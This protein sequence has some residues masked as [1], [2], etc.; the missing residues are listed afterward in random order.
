M[1][2]IGIIGG[3]AAGMMAAAAALEAEDAEIHLFEKNTHLGAKVIISGGGRCN[4]TTGLRD[5]GEVLKRYP[6]GARFIRTAMYAFPPDAVYAWFEQHGVPLKTEKDLRV[7]PRSDDGHDVVDAFEKLFAQSKRVHVHLKT[8]AHEVTHKAG[9][10]HLTT[11]DGQEFVLDSLVLTT[12][13]Q[14]YRQTG[15]TGDGYTFAEAFGHSITPLGPSLNAFVLQE[16]WPKRLSGVSFQKAILSVAK[17]KAFS[18]AA[19]ILLTHK[20]TSG[21]AVFAISAHTAFE[22]FATEQPLPISLDVLPSFA[23]QELTDLLLKAKKDDAKKQLVT[24]LAQLV[25]RSFALE[26]LQELKQPADHILAET[27]DSF[28][29]RLAQWLKHVPLHVIGRSAG[30]EFVTAGGVNTA[31]VDPKTMESRKTPGLFFA[32]EI[33]DVDGYTGGF[34]LQ[35]S[36]ATGRLAGKGASEGKP[37]SA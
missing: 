7:F 1:K 19:P 37:I 2:R 21:P 23:E 24:V 5:L 16:E 8:G 11:K 30:E 13:G 9:K 17:P 3:G 31:E 28:L 22:R 32:G 4:V 33:L 36:W 10:F 26:A 18:Y 29:R 12:G 20:G 27:P 25:P 6:R 34:N 14:A 35:A 15:S